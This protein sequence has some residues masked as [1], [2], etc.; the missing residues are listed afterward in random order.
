MCCMLLLSLVLHKL[1][2]IPRVQARMAETI[3]RFIS[4][5]IMLNCTNPVLTGFTKDQSKIQ[6]K[7]HKHLDWANGRLSHIKQAWPNSP[8]KAIRYAPHL[9]PTLHVCRHELAHSKLAN[10]CTS[11]PTGITIEQTLRHEMHAQALTN[12]SYSKCMGH[13]SAFQ[14]QIRVISAKDTLTQG[15]L[16]SSPVHGVYGQTMGFIKST[17]KNKLT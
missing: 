10:S 11:P 1:L 12:L 7:E 17:R 6:T 2:H 9:I 15:P 3:G 4:I 5:G 16:P 8:A 14:P 13:V